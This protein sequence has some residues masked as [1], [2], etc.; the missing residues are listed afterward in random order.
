[1]GSRLYKRRGNGRF[2]GH[3]QMS[4]LG[5]KAWICAACR[6]INPTD[7]GARPESCHACGATPFIDSADE[8]STDEKT[9]TA[10]T[11]PPTT[12]RTQP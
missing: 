11:A 10:T 8:P 7:L 9:S 5:I 4:D 6:R 2:A 3:F 1:M 12:R